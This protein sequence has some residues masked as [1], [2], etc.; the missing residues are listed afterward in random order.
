[1]TRSL[2]AARSNKR[3]T[4]R[5]YPQPCQQTLP[6]RLPILLLLTEKRVEPVVCVYWDLEVRAEGTILLR[7]L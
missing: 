4:H 6:Q 1:M 3:Q 2:S 7:E 5:S